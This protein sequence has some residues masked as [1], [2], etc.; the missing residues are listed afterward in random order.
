MGNLE[1]GAPQGEIGTETGD[2]GTQMVEGCR[3]VGRGAAGN[4]KGMC[5]KCKK[6]DPVFSRYQLFHDFIYFKIWVHGRQI[7]FTQYTVLI[8]KILKN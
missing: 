4:K 6:T 7:Q 8:N 5:E 3:R 1:S 2:T